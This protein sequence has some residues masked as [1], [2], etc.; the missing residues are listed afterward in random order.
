M[1]FGSNWSYQGDVGLA[2]GDL[3]CQ[4]IGADHVCDYDDIVFAASRGE[5]SSLTTSDTAWLQRT[6]P[7]TIGSSSPKISVLGQPAT[8]GTTYKIDLHGSNC[9][10]WAYSTDHL[11]D[12][13]YVDFSTGANTPTF[14]LDDNPCQIQAL[15]K[16]IPCG[17]NV[18]QRS[19]LCCFPKNSCNP[20]VPT[21]LC[22]CSGT[23][24]Q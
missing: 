1:T 6:H 16:D 4:S 24:C 11:N 3:A 23:V 19:V 18:T 13:E 5:L 20:A 22:T 10:S 7:V 21:S 12:G 17:H 14:H 15:P 8:I 9:V 2:A